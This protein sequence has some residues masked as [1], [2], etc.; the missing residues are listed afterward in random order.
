LVALDGWKGKQTKNQKICA[1][2][3]D[4]SP[5]LQRQ[6]SSRMGVFYLRIKRVKFYKNSLYCLYSIYFNIIFLD[7]TFIIEDY[8]YPHKSVR[9]VGWQVN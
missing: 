8:D 7:Y 3:R 5:N 9:E 2:S 4:V 6:N 1:Q